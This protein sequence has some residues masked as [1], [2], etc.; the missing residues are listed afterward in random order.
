[1][2]RNKPGELHVTTI[3]WIALLPCILAR[4]QE[5]VIS[6]CFCILTLFISCLGFAWIIDFH[7]RVSA[8]KLG[9][10]KVLAH[11]PFGI[12][13]NY[14]RISNFQGIGCSLPFRGNYWEWVAE[15]IF[16]NKFPFYLVFLGTAP[17]LWVIAVGD[18]IHSILENLATANPVE[19]IR[20]VDW[21][22]RS[23]SEKAE[24]NSK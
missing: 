8:K 2:E 15:S 3:S 9:F 16:C 4:G 18:S 22:V 23:W 5:L 13:K 1:M 7:A 10:V 19:S 17:I 14:P 11:P 12:V 20:A 21:E 24:K 6:P